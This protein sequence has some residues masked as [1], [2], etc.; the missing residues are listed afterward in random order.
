MT[1]TPEMNCPGSCGGNLV[2]KEDETGNRRW[3][4]G[5]FHDVNCVLNHYEPLSEQAIMGYRRGQWKI[6]PDVEGGIERVEQTAPPISQEQF[7]ETKTEE[8]PNNVVSL[9]EFRARKAKQ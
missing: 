2:L 7:S 1:R 4:H 9:D 8:K 6:N 5:G 3:K